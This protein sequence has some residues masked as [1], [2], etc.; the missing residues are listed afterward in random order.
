MPSGRT[1]LEH[2]LIAE[3]VLGRRLE[4]WEV[5]H[6]INGRPSDNRVQNL[7]V[8]DYEQHDRYHDWYDWVRKT[9]GKFPRRTTQLRKLREDFRGILLGDVINKKI[10]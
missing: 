10:G 7:C 2:R 4:K 5:V 1:R 8:M 6:H 9:H 3:E